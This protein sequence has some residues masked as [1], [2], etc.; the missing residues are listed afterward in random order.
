MATGQNEGRE[1]KRQ[2]PAISLCMRPVSGG[3]RKKKKKECYL[4]WIL[5]VR[6][7]VRNR[8]RCRTSGKPYCKNDDVL[9]SKCGGGGGDDEEEDDNDGKEEEEEEK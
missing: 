1:T 9:P 3:K 5:L 4:N 8:W 2:S 6:K 7:V